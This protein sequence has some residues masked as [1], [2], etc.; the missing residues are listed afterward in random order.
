MSKGFLVAFVCLAGA[1]TVS[2]DYVNQAKRAG[3]SPG[4]FGAD[5][6]MTS[7]SAR[8][9]D[10]RRT[11]EDDAKRS[12]L[13]QQKRRELLPEAPEGW[14]RHVWGEADESLF[15]TDRKVALPDDLKDEPT[16][17]ALMEMD[18][19]MG[20]KLRTDQSYVYE[21]EGESVAVLIHYDRTAGK[22]GMLGGPFLSLVNGNI[23]AFSGKTGFAVVQGVTFRRDFGVMNFGQDEATDADP[24]TV[25]RA[26]SANLNNQIRVAVTARARDEAI[27]EVLSVIDFDQL[28]F[29]L[30]VPVEG[31]GAAAP[32]IPWESQKAEAD[33]RVAADSAAQVQDAIDQNQKLL[34][35]A[36]EVA[37]RHKG[38]LPTEAEY[39]AEVTQMNQIG[40]EAAA[41]ATAPVEEASDQQE[42]GG[43]FLSIVNGLFAKVSSDDTAGADQAAPAKPT[44]GSFGSGNCTMQGAIKRCST[45]GG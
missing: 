35:W 27:F 36:K 41:P 40:G 3:S 31:I 18:R 37:E 45:S 43:G 9:F 11:I 5:A 28:N 12:A 42:Q 30:D 29:L 8:Y 6:Y 1:G 32:T 15:G 16:L 14:A 20:Q 10:Y 33:A 22:G 13:L 7:I 21:K 26:F 24:A 34:E 39:A 17:T 2:V 19:K 38:K 44:V 4:A 25:T 23:E